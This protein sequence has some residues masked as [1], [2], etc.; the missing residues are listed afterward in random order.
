MKLHIYIIGILEINILNQWHV[1][2][3]EIRSLV[4]Q[5]LL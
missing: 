5:M 1:F 2:T 3:F 4:N